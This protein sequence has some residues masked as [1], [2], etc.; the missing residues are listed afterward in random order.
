M[1]GI[2]TIEYVLGSISHTASYLRLWAL[3]LAHNQLSEV[4]KLREVII[5]KKNCE[6]SQRGGGHP[7]SWKF[8]QLF[9]LH[10]L[11]HPNLQ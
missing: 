2:H 7:K 10:V 11:I 1:T 6:F 9:F 3:S 8:S 4:M 5:Q